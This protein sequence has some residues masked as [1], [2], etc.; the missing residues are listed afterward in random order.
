MVCVDNTYIF[1]NDSIF[2]E[3]IYA[4]P[5]TGLQVRR[6][7][8]LVLVSKIQVNIIFS[9]FLENRDSKKHVL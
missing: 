1:C 6:K 2:A 8:V 9:D 7:T 3:I 4:I 5:A